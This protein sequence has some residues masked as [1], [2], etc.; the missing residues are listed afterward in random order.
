LGRARCSLP[1]VESFLSIVLPYTNAGR[2]KRAVQKIL[3][4]DEGAEM[5]PV[6]VSA[7]GH[8]PELE[9][10]RLS[11]IL[12]RFN[13]HF[14]DIPWEDADRVRE[15]ISETIPARVAEGIAFKNTQANSD[16]QNAKIEHDK[17]LVRVMTAVVDG[18][19]TTER[20]CTSSLVIRQW[21]YK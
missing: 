20:R 14:G 18:P 1:L 7:G 6:P 17:A 2:K 12:K 16:K 8:R 11:N 19:L 5:E 10:D 4:G 15:M 3:L 9:L 13:D 21:P